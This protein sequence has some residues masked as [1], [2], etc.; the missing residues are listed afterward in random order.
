MS[1][2]IHW[3]SQFFFHIHVNIF[4]LNLMKSFMISVRVGKFYQWRKSWEK[5]VFPLGI[6]N[7]PNK[8]N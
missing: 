4:Y 8:W 5:I 1:K 2:T 7:S 3:F 6:S